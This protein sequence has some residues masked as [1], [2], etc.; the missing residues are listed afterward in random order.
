MQKLLLFFLLLYSGSLA[1]QTRV[2]S[3]RVNKLY[4]GTFEKVLDQIST[5]HKVNFVFNRKA[6]SKI[7]L[8][9]RPIDE[10]LLR[11]LGQICAA[12]EL[13]VIRLPDGA[14]K[15]MGAYENPAIEALA[16]KDSKVGA[17][18]KNITVAGLI[19]D[20]TSG[21]ALPFVTVRV[22]GAAIG[23]TAN[24]DGQFTLLNVPTDTSSLIFKY[25]GYDPLLI[26]LRPD[27]P[28]LDMQISMKSEAT[29]EEVVITAEREELLKA[30]EQI[31]ML[32][33]TPSKLATLPSLGERDIFRSFQLMPGISAANE[34]TSGLYVR[35]GT[36][37]QALTLYDG[38]TVYNVDHLFGF[39]SAFNSS[40]IKDV[41]LYKGVFD[42]KYGGR[43][44]SV[45]EI[46]GKDG[47]NRKFNAGGDLS[48]LSANI[49]MEQPFGEKWTTIVTARRSW[50]GPL[51][52]KIFDR[53]SGEAEEESNPFGNRF[54]NAQVASYFYD[55][56]A[57]TTWKPNKKD[58]FSLSFYNGADKLDNSIRP[59]LPDGFAG[60][61]GRLN[62]EITDLTK[63]GNTGASLKWSR[64]WNERL[65]SNSLA[66][67]SNYF[68]KRERSVGGSFTGGD[69]ET[70]DIRR[71][72]FENNNLN[73]VSAKT[74]WEWKFL[75]G[76]QLE[77]GA[78]A[79]QND[80]TY[81]YAQSD[82]ASLLDRS[83]NGLTATAYL[84]DKASFFK[85]KLIITP[86]LRTSY[87]SPTGKMYYEPRAN[88]LFKI[89]DKF[90]LKAAT[91]LYYQFAKRVIREDILS[92][93]RD[94]W[95]LTD[96]VRLP[97]ASSK[98]YVAG[99][100]W[101]N[102]TW[103][104]DAEAYYKTLDGLTEYSLRFTPTGPGGGGPGGGGGAQVSYEENFFNGTGTARGIDLLLQKKHGRFN[105]WI[106][107]TLGDTRQNY[108]VYGASDFYASN[109]VTH[110]FK[111]VGLY[112]W[113]KWDFSAT[114]IYASGK[115]YTAPEG[116]YQITLLDGTT[117][118]FLNVSAK[119]AYRLPDYHRIDVAATYNFWLGNAPSTL[120]LSIF[121][122]YNRANVWYK[123]F[124]II[125]NQVIATD[126]NYLGI[127]PNITLGVKLR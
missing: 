69:G 28:L 117:Q 6:L 114:W 76:Q 53:F 104:F 78:S 105:G 80:I 61:G 66:S 23:V 62:L 87:F 97:V 20:R 2:D 43:L 30:S 92:G 81:T 35:G 39:F 101:E 47:N 25:V 65:Y 10:P 86:G 73:D 95:V 71:G 60:G 41:Q 14:L 100:S 67:Y 94:F 122:L 93:S 96:G 109:D 72:T 3:V 22:V 40:S 124:E 118:D 120:G 119:N 11:F 89:S 74:D 27:A 29:L 127:T 102:R 126:V 107:Y 75:P 50:K 19:T 51:Y 18:Q 123:E 1:A 12:H 63:W 110:E 54:G 9:E 113:R 46:T 4:L 91:G 36:P 33:M 8:V 26:Y 82:T 45:V 15:I 111:I 77:F 88:I 68:S 99:F 58:V 84:Q 98:Q 64:K 83:S 125:D 32:K 112:K 44:S 121:N 38:F 115:P 42:A 55:V 108:P 103:L 7:D 48:L 31:S 90:K 116:G 5:E 21:E 106:G 57:K 16:T 70:Q 34:H 52:E 17:K 49:W 56:N 59:Q 24:V 13:K 79:T 85:E 37:D